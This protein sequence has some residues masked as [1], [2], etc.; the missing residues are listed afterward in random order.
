MAGSIFPTLNFFPKAKLIPT[1]NI[2]IDPMKDKSEIK[3]SFKKGAI[4]RDKIV[5]AP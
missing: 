1:P 3:A 2:N 4:K 5:I